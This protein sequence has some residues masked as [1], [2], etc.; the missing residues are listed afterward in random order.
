[1]GRPP[2]IRHDPVFCAMVYIARTGGPWRE[3]PSCYGTGQPSYRRVNRGGE[4][5]LW[6]RVLRPLQQGKNVTMTMGLADSTTMKI[7]RH[8]GG[9]AWSRGV[10]R[11]GVTTTLQL[12]LTAEDPVVEGS[13]TGGNVSDLTKAGELTAEVFGCDRVEDR[14]DDSAA[15]RRALDHPQP[16]PCDPGSYKPH[17]SRRLRQG[18]LYTSPKERAGLRQ[19]YGHPTRRSSLVSRSP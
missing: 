16:H 8:G 3:R 15:H 11:A 7:H 5:G 17:R 2:T 9:G 19:D 10:T 18:H 4:K 13:L 1:M 14:G 6:W 12:A